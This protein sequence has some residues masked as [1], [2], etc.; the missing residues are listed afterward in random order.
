[1]CVHSVNIG[2]FTPSQQTTYT[3]ANKEKDGLVRPLLVRYL[4]GFD[5]SYKIII[6]FH[7]CIAMENFNIICFYTF[8]TYPYSWKLSWNI[9]SADKWYKGCYWCK[10]LQSH[11]AGSTSST[12]YLPYYRT[13]SW[14]NK[15]FLQ[16][17]STQP[18]EH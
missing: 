14:I 18:K 6:P 5:I 10:K 2:S 7:F 13:L 4:I 15:V 12:L 9:F 1:M 16:I 8:F 17:P 11:T 3:C